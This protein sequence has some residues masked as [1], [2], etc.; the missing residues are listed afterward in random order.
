MGLGDITA[1]AVRA[2]LHEHDQVGAEEFCGRY[3]FDRFRNHLIADDGRRYGTRVIAAAAYG[4]LPGRAPLSPDDVADE[5]LVNQTLTGLGFEVRE[6]RPP[7]W[8]REELILACSLLF[9]NNRVAQRVTDRPVQDLA[10]FLQQLPFHAPQDR[11]LNFRSVNSVQRKLFDLMTRLPGYTKKKTRGGTLDEQ[12]LTEFLADED[13]MHKQAA[14]IRA[15]HTPKAWALFSA[16]GDR[17]YGGN[18][19]YP[20]VLGSSYVYDNKVGNSKRLRKGH[21]I[22]VRNDEDALGIARVSRIEEQDGVPKLQR[23]CP[24]PDCGSKFD[25]RSKQRP[26]YR[27]RKDDCHF[28]FD[29]PAEKT[30]EVTQYVAYYGG[31]WRALDGAITA[32][33]LKQ[34]CTDGAVQNAIR[35]LDVG[36]LEAMLE[37]VAVQLPPELTETSTTAKVESTR[38][39]VTDQDEPA[40]S[41]QDSDG[42]TDGQAPTGGRREV[43]TKARI[44]QKPFRK[45]LIKRYGHVCAVTG[46]AP[47]EVLQAAHLR[48][49]AEHESHNLD[50]G[51]LLRADVHLLFDN[52][53]L[54]VD[55]TTWKVVLAPSLADYPDYTKL[56]GA[57]FAKGPCPKA[58]TDHFLAVTATWT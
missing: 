17:K 18:N 1:E 57:D 46:R 30:V 31:T 47:A 34:A 44:G 40:T 29:E 52:N 32:E 54:A 22:V 48:D 58:I 43:R 3:G 53:L 11:G 24:K 4:H 41:D 26:K 42:R 6:Q 5:D 39:K 50:E 7:K 37:R 21:V 38:R 10:L 49:F 28:E 45:E 12:I 9:A 15:E 23:G 36:K 20:D 16:D 35:P 55:P 33:E 19:G 2:A 51:V 8:T 14:A 56:N 13:G 25:E 27:C